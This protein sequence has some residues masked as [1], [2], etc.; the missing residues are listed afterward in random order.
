MVNVLFFASL[1]EQA[2][3]DS[4]QLPLPEPANIRQLISLIAEKHG[5]S[6]EKHLL[7]DNI[8]IAINYET[9]SPEAQVRENDEIAFYPPV[10]GG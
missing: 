4:L 7:E 8:V 1:R 10:T 9:A 3:I 2:G 6:L 5:A